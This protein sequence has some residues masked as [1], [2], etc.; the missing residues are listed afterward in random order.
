MS[1]TGSS[2]ISGNCRE[3]T[4]EK[5]AWD[6]WAREGGRGVISEYRVYWI[7]LNGRKE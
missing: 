7:S 6:Q 4:P 3:V 5:D 2:N 1:L